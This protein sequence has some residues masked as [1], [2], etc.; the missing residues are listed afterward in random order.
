[1]EFGL[2]FVKQSHPKFWSTLVIPLQSFC[3]VCYPRLPGTLLS[4]IRQIG[5]Y[6]YFQKEP[7]FSVVATSHGVNAEAG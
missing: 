5:E 7:M 3:W 4:E 2:Y 6:T 1:M